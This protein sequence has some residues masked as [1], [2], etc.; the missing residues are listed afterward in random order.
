MRPEARLAA[1]AEILDLYLAGEPAEK[2]LTNWARRSRFA[3][4]KDRAAVRDHVF[5]AIRQ[6]RSAAWAGGAETGR[7]L[8]IGLLRL[9]GLD[10][11]ASLTGQGYALSPL[12]E[13]EAAVADTAPELVALDCPD[14][15]EADLRSSL[16][17]DFAPVLQRLRGRADL[18]LRANL[19]RCTPTEAARALAEDGVETEPHPLCDTALRVLG[20][21][22][23][24]R[25][26][27]AYRD[28]LIEIQDAA[29]QAVAAAV[30]LPASGR[31]LDYCAGGGGKA[32][33]LAARKGGEIFVHDGNPRRMADIPERARR[34]A[35]RLTPL[36]ESE[37]EAGAYDLVVTDVPCSGSGAWRRQ[38]N[39]K[40]RLDADG[41]AGILQLQRSILSRASDLVAPGGA[42]A[43]MTCSLLDAENEAQREQFLA[44]RPG[45]RL[46][47]EIRLSPL[48]GGDGFFLA[49]LRTEGGA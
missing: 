5:D 10:P 47:R 9:Q 36:E 23:A 6:R 45:W 24:L 33:A 7:G 40:W 48:Q 46:E 29:S 27:Q 31:V 16:G 26:G 3:G 15:L 41:L 49:I 20:G 14:W 38:P 39:A 22:R 44:E 8:V 42:L 17:A 19:L 28:G 32:L 30:P 25:N 11:A 13:D 18:F 35:A 1:A 4:A 37:L 12:R 34:A 2:A 43:Y 21:A